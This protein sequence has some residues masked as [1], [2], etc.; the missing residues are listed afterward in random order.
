MCDSYH[1]VNFTYAG[2]TRGCRHSTYAAACNDK[3]G[4]MLALDFR[5]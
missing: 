3:V 2:M 4:I 1:D 5:C